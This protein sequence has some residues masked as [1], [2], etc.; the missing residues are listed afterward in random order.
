MTGQ[1][2]ARAAREEALAAIR[3]EDF[4]GASAAARR[5]VELEPGNPDGWWLLGIAAMDLWG[6]SDAERAFARGAACLPAGHPLRARFLT[7][8]ARVL[9]PLGRNAEA[10]ATAKQ[11][12]VAGAGDPVSL[13]LLAMVLTRASR[14]TEALP[15]LQKAVAL[16]PRNASLWYN[17][18]DLQQYLGQTDEA[19]R[20]Y[21]KALSLQPHV[22]PYLALARLRKWTPEQNHIEAIKALPAP[23]PGEQA[24][25]A[26]ALFKEYDDLG[27]YASAWEWLQKG[28]EAALAQPM[29]SQSPV[30]TLAEEAAM[31]A[32]WKT[33][34]PPETFANLPLR[35]LS[36]PRRIF[37]VG[38]PRS[39]TTLIERILT[40]HSQ[41][42]AL[43][44]LHSFAMVTKA[45]AGT[46]T[47]AMLD[48]PTIAAVMAKD[49]RS[50][51]DAYD[52]ETAYLSD[53][54]AFTID[55][56][57]DNYMYAGLIRLAC[58]DAVIIHTRRGAM[59]SLFGTYKMYFEE[60]FRWSYRQADLADHYQ[61]Y[62][63]LMAHWKTCLGD[64]LI[65]IS[66]ES[67]IADPE[68]EIRRLLAAAGLPFEEACLRPHE[69]KG[70]I[71]TPSA[72]QVR[73]PINAEGVGVWRR[74][75][76]ELEPLRQRLEAMGLLESRSE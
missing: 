28:A 23:S 30:W 37:I 70:A 26:Y 42:Q 52:R 69:A 48:P 44:E 13:S 39:G 63:D 43:G 67:L 75:A 11:A 31:V 9:I 45:L 20:A 24:R 2:P 34:L 68:D 50:L 15:L 55:K 71:S 18:G 12:L 76:E 38:L 32:A 25:K 65:E 66:L 56:M 8:Q 21:E 4:S 53:G 46:Q 58:P 60:A 1:G 16:D 27:D 59:D 62:V 35:Q 64:G 49:P 10:Y 40:A 74:Y 54:S 3:R 41:V 29:S 19:E 6:Y 17:L 36:G 73:K 57:P 5:S 51:A 61:Q 47:L 33:H 22:E 7:Q 72:G 14:Q